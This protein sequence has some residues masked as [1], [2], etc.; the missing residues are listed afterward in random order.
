VRI[1]YFGSGD[2]SLPIVERLR[3]A[4]EMAG[5]VIVKPKPR[6]RGLKTSPPAI[7]V[8][9][10]RNRVDVFEPGSPNDP[11][12]ITRMN[13]LAPDLFVL[14]AY[15]H[16]LG[17]DLL[18]VPRL[19][20]I[21]IHPSLLPR[22]RGAAPIQRAIMAGEST[23][24]LTVFFMDE[25][26]DHGEVI[27]QREVAI[28]DEDD[29]GSLSGRLSNLAADSIT[30][31][32]SCVDLGTCA[33]RPQDDAGK[34]TAPKITREETFIDWNRPARSI[35]NLVRALSPVPGARTS[36]RGRE[37]TVLKAALTADVFEP[38]AFHIRERSLYAGAVGGALQITR[39]KPEN[40]K[41]MS[42]SDFINGFRVKEGEEI[43]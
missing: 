13:D 39:L 22:Y 20:A 40:G 30:D 28:T 25:K 35:F 33:R 34:T 4:V 5:V 43:K 3:P 41:A 27:F 8:W 24:G 6:G 26:I 9:A 14:S 23:T 18:A 16:I 29:Y 32:I 31:V 38:R 11:V 12:F 17:R 42:G 37:L 19:G 2:F 10:A 7:A 36:F 1:V 21:N 15:G